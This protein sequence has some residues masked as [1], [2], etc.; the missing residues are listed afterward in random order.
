[1]GPV[2]PP[3]VIVI[4]APGLIGLGAKATEFTL[5]P[6]DALIVSTMHVKENVAEPPGT[7]LPPELGSPSYSVTVR[8]ETSHEGGTEGTWTK[9]KTGLV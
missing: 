3:T 8:F 5:F 2:F 1:M 7:R 9:K 6:T 4:G